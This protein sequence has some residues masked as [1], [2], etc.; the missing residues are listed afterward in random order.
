MKW[1]VCECKTLSYSPFGNWLRDHTSWASSG[2]GV[3]IKSVPSTSNLLFS[4]FTA[5]IYAF[6]FLNSKTDIVHIIN[7]E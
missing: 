7:C 3:K 4:N 2:I 1:C 6:L 5:K